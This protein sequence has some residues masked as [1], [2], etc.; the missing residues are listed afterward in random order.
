MG[1]RMGWWIEGLKW[2]KKRLICKA[3]IFNPL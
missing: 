1:I 2:E 3:L